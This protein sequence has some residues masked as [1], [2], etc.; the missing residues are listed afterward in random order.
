M[1]YRNQTSFEEW[2]TNCGYNVARSQFAS[3]L[4]YADN[5]TEA[6]FLAWKAGA[7]SVVFEVTSSIPEPESLIDRVFNFMDRLAESRL[8]PRTIRPKL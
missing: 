2:A 6:A 1:S 8:N 4:R 3:E 5:E 7:R